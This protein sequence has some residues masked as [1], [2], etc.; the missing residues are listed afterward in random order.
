MPMSKGEEGAGERPRGHRQVAHTADRVV[1]AWGR[2]RATCIAEALSG[3][4]ES[5]ADVSDTA[6]ARPLPLAAPPGGAEE[7]LVSMFEDVIY[8]V[9]VFGVVPV[10]FHLSE[11]EDGGIAGD[12][13]VV[14]S[15]QVEVVGPV[16]K[17][18][19]YHDLS[20]APFEGGWRCHV[21]VDV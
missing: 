1:E 4:V 5:F 3:L 20:V 17:A 9:D 10:R 6:A 12:M 2:D 7:A 16:P 19:S 8:T 14:P 15:A 21:L 11:T 18:V 13:E